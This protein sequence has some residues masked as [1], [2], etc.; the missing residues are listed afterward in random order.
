MVC[1]DN[2]GLGILLG[3]VLS[4]QA[5]AEDVHFLEASTIT[6]KLAR[7]LERET[8]LAPRGSS[9]FTH[10]YLYKLQ[11]LPLDSV[12]PLL[13]TVEEAKYARFIFQSQTVPSKI[14]TLMSRSSVVR[15]PFIPKSVVLANLKIMAHDARIADQL[16]LWDGTLA[17]TITSLQMKDA[18]TSI[19]REFKRGSRGFST[20]MSPE[21]LQAT[22][23]ILTIEEFLSEEEKRFLRRDESQI[24]KK[25]V[26]LTAME[27]I[28]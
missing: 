5:A 2:L 22:S 15:L 9:E 23:F 10:Y 1:P 20:M 21:I 19:L 3:N 26:L 25:L 4:R 18:K 27:R 24:R 6:K 12:G 11:G 8:R 28:E 13:K 14:R 7:E 17:G 16:N